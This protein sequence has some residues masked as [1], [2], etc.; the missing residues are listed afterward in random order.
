[1]GQLVGVWW[2]TAFFCNCL[3]KIGGASFAISLAFVCSFVMG[4]FRAKN[5]VAILLEGDGSYSCLK[6]VGIFGYYN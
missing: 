1:M 5:L 4:A 2:G 6:L 3:S